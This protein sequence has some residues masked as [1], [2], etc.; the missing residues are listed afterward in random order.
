VPNFNYCQNCG[1]KVEAKPEETYKTHLDANKV[2]YLKKLKAA[3]G[4]AHHLEL[5]LTA[6]EQTNCH[7]ITYWG[8]TELV[9][10]GTYRLTQLGWDFVNGK[11]QVYK[12]CVRIKATKKTKEFTGKLVT[13]NDYAEKPTRQQIIESSKTLLLAPKQIGLDIRG[14][15]G[16]GN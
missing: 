15:L 8:L 14:A 11:T 10:D 5:G 1:H 4:M 9:K 13:I 7:A 6:S 16:Y 3:G 2:G 12:T